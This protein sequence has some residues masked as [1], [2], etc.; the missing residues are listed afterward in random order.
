MLQPHSN[1]P[2]VPRGFRVSDPDHKQRMAQLEA[3]LAAAKK[4][5]EPPPPKEDHH[6]QAQVGWRMVTELVAG[7]M[8]GA[9]L[10]YGLDTLAGTLPWGLVIF[11]MLGFAAGVKTMMRSAQEFQKHN[12]AP[13][14][15][16]T[17]ARKGGT[18]ERV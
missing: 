17:G 9:T 1:I 2:D 7:L 3:R 11:T 18:D 10:G 14:A 4:A 8:I 6:A 15:E 12:A 13:E 16:G 5:Q